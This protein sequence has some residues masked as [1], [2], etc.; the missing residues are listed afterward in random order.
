MRKSDWI[1]WNKIVHWWVKQFELFRHH[2][3]VLFSI[4]EITWLDILEQ[5]WT[6]VKSLDFKNRRY[7]WIDHILQNN[8]MMEET[9]YF[10]IL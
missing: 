5:D 8:D 2:A 4:N 1:F 6:S 7:I 9:A 10:P 3:L